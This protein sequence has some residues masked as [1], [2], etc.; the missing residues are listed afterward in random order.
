MGWIPAEFDFAVPA[1][2]EASSYHFE[3]T[4]PSELQVV[5]SHLMVE[6]VDEVYVTEGHTVGPRAHV[7]AGQEDPTSEGWA[8]VWL[9]APRTGLLRASFVV[10]GLNLLLIAFFLDEARITE[11]KS[12][13]PAA[14]LLAI[15]ALVSSF[16]V[17]PGEHS[18]ATQLLTGIRL[19]VGMSGLS[20]FV[21]ATL[22]VAEIQGTALLNS[23]RVL[24]AAAGICFLSCLV[25]FMGFGPVGWIGEARI[26]VT[27]LDDNEEHGEE[28]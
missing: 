17:R 6:T 9:P 27:D 1:I 20:A 13:E 28:S 7:Y 12:S 2:G 15:P 21:G 3:F 11:I 16:I 19:A 8:S 24:A 23:W 26:S 22:L 5:A 14:I 10:T 18:L 4:T 25:A